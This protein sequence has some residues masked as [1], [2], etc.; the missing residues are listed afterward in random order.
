[1]NDLWESTRLRLQRT[2]SPEAFE[3]WIA[4]IEFGGLI[5][6]QLTLRVPNSFQLE[7]V[8]NNYESLMLELCQDEARYTSYDAP[9]SIVLTIDPNLQARATAAICCSPPER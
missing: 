6:G 5:D 3:S 2:I 8:H 1:M 9:T 4:D 7:W